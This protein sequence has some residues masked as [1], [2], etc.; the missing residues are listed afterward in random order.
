MK[1]LKTNLTSYCISHEYI[2]YLDTLKINIIGSNGFKK[3]YPTHWLNDANGKNISKKNKNYGTLTSIYWVWKN[4][5]K[6][7]NPNDF[8]GICHYRRFW[9]KKNHEKKINLKN[10][11][12]NILFNIP[13]K[14]QNFD[15]FVCKPQSLK[16]YKFSKLFKKGKRNILKNPSIIFNK[17]K[18]TIKLHFDMFHI[19][20]GLEKSIKLLNTKDKEDFL[21]YV[22]F[23]TKFH[24]LSI[25]IIKKKYF[26]K[27]CESTFNWLSKCEKIFNKRNLK[28]Y[29]EVRIF[30][31]LAERYFSFWIT[32]YCKYKTWPYKLIDTREKNI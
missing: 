11:K 25:F 1:K 27:L 31:F 28:T 22:N 17:S 13:K 4:H 9:L 32:K 5:I 23:Q 7:L 26:L 29:G 21:N 10:L 24:P 12:K 3:K 8:I 20:N 14:Y 19:Y 30:D 15:C 2:N 16:G 6:S 18:H